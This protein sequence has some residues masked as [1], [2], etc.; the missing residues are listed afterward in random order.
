M[1]RSLSTGL[2]RSQEVSHEFFS[3]VSPCIRKNIPKYIL[4]IDHTL[5]ALLAK[6]NELGHEQAIYYLVRAMVK[7]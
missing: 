2:R 6:N 1:G 3:V 7:A 4:V 5:S